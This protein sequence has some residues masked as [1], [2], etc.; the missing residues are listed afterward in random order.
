MK[1]GK[2][3]K[4]KFKV[5]EKYSVLLLIATLLMSIG[6][7]EMSGIT[8]S[9][10]ANVK[11]TVQDGVFITEVTRTAYDGADI[12][13]SKI[14]SYAETTMNNTVVLGSSSDSTITYNVWLYNNSDKDHVFIGITKDEELYKNTNITY[15][16]DLVSYET[17]IKAGQNMDFNITFSYAGSDVSNNTLNS[18]LNFRFMEVPKLE[19]CSAGNI[20][21]MYP[22]VTKEA[23]FTVTNYDSSGVNGVPLDYTMVATIY[24]ANGAEV[25]APITATICDE[26]GTAV[27]SSKSMPKGEETTHT[28][29][30]KLTWDVSNNSTDYVGKTYSYK[31]KTVAVPNKTATEGK[32]ETYTLMNETATAKITTAPFYFVTDPTSADSPTVEMADNKAAINLTISNNDGTNY[33]PFET[34]YTIAL[35]NTDFILYVAGTEYTNNITGE[36]QLGAGALI[37]SVEAIELKPKTTSTTLASEEICN[38]TITTTSP[39]VKTETI[40][41]IATDKTVPTAPEIT[42]GSRTYATSQTISV[43]KEAT[44]VGTGVKY[45]QYI[46]DSDGQEI[47]TTATGNV[48][49][50][51]S[52]TSHTFNTDYDGYYVYFRA[53][54]GVGNVGEWSNAERLYID[55]NPPTVSVKSTETETVEENASIEISTYFNISENGKAPITSEVYTDTSDGDKIVTNTSELAVGTH[56]VKCTVTKENGLVASAT[57]TV[58]IE[59][60]GPLDVTTATI[61]QEQTTEYQDANNNKIVVP[62]GFKVRTDLATTVEEGIVIEDS[63]SNQFV[64]IPV[65]DVEKENGEVVNIEFGRYTFDATTGEPELQQSA[66]DYT[67]SGIIETYYQEL[68][69]SRTGSANGGTD[70]W[71]ATALN[72]EEFITNTKNNKGYYLARFESS[73]NSKANSIENA[74]V[75]MVSQPTAS[76]AARAMYSGNKYVISDLVNSYAWDTALVFINKCSNVSDYAIKYVWEDM[77][78]GN[79]GTLGDI[80]CNISDM[81][82]NYVEWSTEHMN[83]E[84]AYWY[85]GS[86]ANRGMFT[87]R[88]A[89]GRDS[90]VLPFATEAPGAIRVVLYLQ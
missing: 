76:V 86:D 31:I 22:G 59:R 35:D 43:S 15:S 24:D 36:I 9:V 7:A 14:N 42:G 38:I 87:V 28:Y 4:V 23:S 80:V 48:G 73:N 50:T 5:V 70:Q 20:V 2:H 8:L 63:D 47:A 26:S 84:S 53:V 16:T 81:A 6:Y 67:D 78:T 37:N 89:G 32:Y 65:G 40:K 19:V 62:G 18:I 27:T 30:L 13:N 61:I 41:I 49:S 75:V 21:D 17:T 56:I 34:K 77:V 55:I 66:D 60:A 58:I 64:W 85:T 54:D 10:A 1:E 46:I 79:T 69:I 72:L 52:E 33:N 11:A 39:Y 68:T 29:K 74:E 83:K 82:G 12:T 57:K 90:I 88:N 51:A 25:T 45:Y 44:D 3:K 71:N